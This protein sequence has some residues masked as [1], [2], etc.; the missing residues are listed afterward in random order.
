MF[1]KTLAVL[2]LAVA[3]T[4]VKAFDGMDVIRVFAGFMDG[5][6]QKD[7]LDYLMGCMTGTD[8]LVGD[9]ENA[10]THF[11]QGGTMGIGLGIMDIGKFLQDLPPTCY[12]CGG[13]PDDF[14]KLS[15]FFSI[16]GN[17]SLL[18]ERVSYNLLWYYSDINADIQTALVDWNNSQYFNFGE[19]I[20]EALVLAVGDHSSWS[21]NPQVIQ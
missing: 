2:C 9:I 14:A 13:I 18:A 8:A 20:G 16:F 10:V 15:Q 12:N 4:T 7:N 1:K 19:K 3:T 5:V 11:S 21:A 17:A 6:I